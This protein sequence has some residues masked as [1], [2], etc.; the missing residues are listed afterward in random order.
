MSRHVKG[1]LF[2]DYVRM[3][4]S[5]KQVDWSRRLDSADL[6]LLHRQ[7]NPDEWYSMEAF[8][9]FGLAILE[10][11]AHGDLIAVR[12]W[13]RMSTEFQVATH[14]SLLVAGDPCESM[15]RFLVLRLSFFDFEVLSIPHLTDTEAIIHVHYGMSL[16]AEQAAC[17][18]TLG[19]LSRLV[20]LA[21]GHKVV[22]ALK[23]RLWEGD[24]ATVISIEWRREP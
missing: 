21:G 11:I 1:S 4:R 14:P 22:A 18:Q 19:F 12:I 24:P 15:M 13:G 23:Q 5:Q 20:E 16:H 17:F 10:D 6:A 3:L 9:R 7:V 2:V 8:E